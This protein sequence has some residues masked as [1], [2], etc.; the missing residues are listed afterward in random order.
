LGKVTCLLLLFDWRIGEAL[1]D[2]RDYD[3]RGS[4]V[5]FEVEDSY[6]RCED[7]ADFSPVDYGKGEA[8]TI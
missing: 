3:F 1:L 7:T 5:I 4:P 2:Q 6:C 8:L